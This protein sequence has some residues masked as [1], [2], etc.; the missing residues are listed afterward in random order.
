MQ[1]KIRET[2]VAILEKSRLDRRM[3][4]PTTHIDAG[5]AMTRILQHFDSHPLAKII[6]PV[7]LPRILHCYR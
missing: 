4:P 6:D 5:T 7:A 2:R 3:T 1:N